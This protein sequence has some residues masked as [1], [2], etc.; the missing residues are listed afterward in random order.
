MELKSKKLYSDN[1]KGIRGFTMAY[2]GLVTFAIAY[3]ELAQSK[4]SQ[5][6]SGV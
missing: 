6:V 4:L 2:K 1:M 3:K 5:A